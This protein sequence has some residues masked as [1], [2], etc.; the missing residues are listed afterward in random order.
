MY[1]SCFVTIKVLR[2][3]VHKSTKYEYRI[4]EFITIMFHYENKTTIKSKTSK[5]PKRNHNEA[6]HIYLLNT[7]ILLWLFIFKIVDQ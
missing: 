6:S 3:P 4:L 5:K 1:T 2:S 7:I